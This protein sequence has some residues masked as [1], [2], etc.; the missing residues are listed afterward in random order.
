MYKPDP[1]TPEQ[2]RGLGALKPGDYE[3]YRERLNQVCLEGREIMCRSSVSSMARSG[4]LIVAI[5][6]ASGDYATSVTG[7]YLHAVLG[8]IVVKWIARNWLKNPTV[9]V[10]DGDIFYCNDSL[11]GGLHNQDQIAVIPVFNDG[12]LI[13]WTLAATHQPETGAVDPGSH[14]ADARSMLYEGMRLSPIKIGT[15][16][17]LHDDKLE[18]MENLVFR[19]P[20]MQNMD[21]RARCTGC[22]RM[23][24]RLVD[25]AREK[26]NLFIHGILRRMLEEA[27]TAMRTK[28][29]RWNDGTFR[30]ATFT[31]S[32]GAETTL[33]RLFATLKKEGDHVSIDLSGTSPEHDGGCLQGPNQGVVSLFCVYLFAH[34]THDVPPSTGTLAAVDFNIPAGTW[35]NPHPMA[36]RSGSAPALAPI[37]TISYTLFGKMLFDSADRYLVTA[38]NVNQCGAVIFGVNQWGVPVGDLVAYTLNA[39]GQGARHD[40]D[41]VDAYGFYYTHF[42]RGPDAE[43]WENV[44]AVVHLFQG[45]LTDSCGHGK[46]RGG[47]GVA[48]AQMVYGAPW[49]AEQGVVAGQRMSLGQGLFGG[50]PESPKTWIRIRNTDVLEKMK[51]GDRDIPKDL[52]QMVGERAIGGDYECEDYSHKATILNEGDI[53][54]DVS[55]G[56]PGYG[57][58]LERDPEAVM[59]DIRR[60]IISHRSAQKV[61]LVAYDKESL[62]VDYQETDELRRR[63]RE[64]RKAR[65]K[66]YDQFV[67]AW[68]QKRPPEDALTR[69]GSWPDARKTREIVWV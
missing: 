34:A 36:P 68:S 45:F 47:S 60:G 67:K 5:Y 10:N 29:S 15:N 53:F 9:G 54:V 38:P 3:I 20:R 22:D 17:R 66:S 56:G 16:F 52:R 7:T 63:E 18:M 11:Y 49:Y 24:R 8:T 62:E 57:D 33:L 32:T 40:M 30:I 14:V 2:E 59:K 69:Y 13:A 21:V 31:D 27:E 35:V 61:Y 42:A 64:S 23:R 26:G 65:G 12:E 28:L 55:G 19:T 58:V 51:R 39:C 25:L 37:F 41:G 46:Y 1:R 50:Y 43:E 48:T 44:H 6:T 4:D